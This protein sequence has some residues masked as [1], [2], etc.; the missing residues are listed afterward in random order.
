MIRRQSRLRAGIVLAGL[1]A[2]LWLV[3][4]STAQSASADTEVHEAP[5]GLHDF[6]FTL[7]C[8]YYE[9]G[10]VG[11]TLTEYL[12]SGTAKTYTDSP[13]TAPFAARVLVARPT[14]PSAFNGTVLAEW[15][16]VT[17][18]FPAGP[19]MVWLHHHI[20]PKGY[21]YVAVNAQKV[22]H[23]FLQK[24][25]PVRYAALG[26]HPGD[27]YSYDIYS[28]SVQAITHSS[29]M[30][31]LAVDN[32][33]G[34]GQSQS[35]GRLNNYMN[36]AQNDAGVLDAAIIQADGGKQKSFPDLR[37]P[38]VQFETEDS[39]TSTAPDPKNNPHFY[40]L[41][42]VVGTAHLGSENQSPGVLTVPTAGVTGKPKL[43][44]SL[45]VAY[46][47]HNHYGEEG[48]SPS[49]GAPVPDTGV[50]PPPGTIPS[51]PFVP[52]DTPGAAGGCG[53]NEMPFRYAL[54]AALEGLHYHLLG[55]RPMVPQP[56]RATF[57]DGVLQRD[58]FGN[59]LGGLRLPP[60]DV[61][62]ATYRPDG[63]SLFGSTTPLSQA[64][65]L[66]EYPTHADYVARMDKAIDDAVAKRYMT[67][68]GGEQMHRK[69]DRSRIPLWS[70][71]SQYGLEDGLGG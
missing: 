14:D 45:D 18:Q 33:I 66:A 46:W 62:V 41:W 37:V 60:I 65:L 35:A 8:C 9:F 15:E 11:Y 53:G 1:L 39:I 5:S 57:V 67:P 27:D 49:T 24:W 4:A 30:D 23:D 36:L 40:R 56:P 61:P 42:E 69:A 34:Y 51:A 64:Q 10:D 28:Q 71:S 48:P 3:P 50:H 26:V 13:T 31:G 52:K 6:P 12:V 38:L 68:E 16:N 7:G 47:E 54:E 32:I 25:D 55:E 29:V 63:C 22:G 44:W 2:C 20:L 21:A 58:R 17:G 59:A 19:G 70:P 43:P